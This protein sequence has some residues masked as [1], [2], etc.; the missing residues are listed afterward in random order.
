MTNELKQELK[1]TG[2]PTAR[3]IYNT[4]TGEWDVRGEQNGGKTFG[5]PWSMSALSGPQYADSRPEAEMAAVVYLE[6]WRN[7]E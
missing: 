2:D 6:E 5:G 3:F 1:L 7:N 4:R